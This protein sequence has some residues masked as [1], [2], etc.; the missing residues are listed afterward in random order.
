MD[1]RLF[2]VNGKGD[3][4]LKDTLALAFKQDGDNTTCEAWIETQDH[5][6]ILLWLHRD[7]SNRLPAKMTADGIFQTVKG[8]L[9]S[10][11]AK[12]VKL[13]E[14]CGDC[15]HDGHNSMGWQVYCEDWGHV[16]N[17]P[18]AICAIKPAFMW[19]GK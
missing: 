16:A 4:M 5:G 1:N 10:E 3:Q 7:G 13:S 12:T 9:S 17:N 19:H 11:F 2:N 18:Y 14:W 8:W 6:L 15:D